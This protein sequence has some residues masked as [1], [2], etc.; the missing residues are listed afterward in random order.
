[1]LCWKV[2]KKMRIVNEAKQIIDAM[3]M[4]D[5]DYVVIC[6]TAIPSIPN[7]LK[8]LLLHSDLHSSYIQTKHNGK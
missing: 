8:K 3:D 7:T 1:M 5:S 6:T 4:H 2:I